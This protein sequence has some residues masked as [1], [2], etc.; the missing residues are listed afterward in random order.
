MLAKLEQITE[1]ASVAD[2]K[3]AR[4]F[5]FVL[6]KSAKPEALP[7]G[8]TLAAALARRK[9]KPEDLAKSPIATDLP[10]GALAAWVALDPAK[11]MFEQH[12]LLRKAL[13]LLLAEKP[14]TLG[15][16]VFG[17]AA[18]RERAARLATYAAWVNGAPLPERKKKAEAATLRRVRLHG[19]RSA[20]GY[21]GERAIAGPQIHDTVSL[22]DR[23]KKGEQQCIE[24]RP[25]SA[26]ALIKP[27]SPVKERIQCLIRNRRCCGAINSIGFAHRCD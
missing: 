21:A 22:S 23:N 27:Q 17:T 9:K 3:V 2:L 13:S 16:G 1:P 15:I 11:S 24:R 26:P 5:L 19:H 7:F 25:V 12:T 18:E 10:Q 14:E 6:P 8:D 20:D 4:H